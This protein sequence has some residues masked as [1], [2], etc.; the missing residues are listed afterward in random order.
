MHNN[1][2]VVVKDRLGDLQIPG[3]GWEHGESFE[4][5]LRREVMEELGVGIKIISPEMFMYRAQ[6]QRGYLSLRIA[7]FI[8]PENYHFT[9]GDDMVEAKLV[10]K[11]EFLALSFSGGE[12]PIQDYVDRI[13]QN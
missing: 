9:P 3:G 1:K 12:G 11:K 8:T 10:S 6:D 2:L 5:C 4:D 7:C 13:W